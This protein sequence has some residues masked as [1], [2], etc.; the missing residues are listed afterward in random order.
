LNLYQYD[1]GCDGWAGEWAITYSENDLDTVAYGGAPEGCDSMT[2]LELELNREY[3]FSA[4]LT[5]DENADSEYSYLLVRTNED[6]AVDTISSGYAGQGNGFYVNDYSQDYGTYLADILTPDECELYANENG[7]VW[8]GIFCDAEYHGIEGG[9]YQVGNNTME[10]QSNDESLCE[11]EDEPNILFI[12]NMNFMEFFIVAFFNDWESADSLEIVN[13]V[14]IALE[15]GDDGFKIVDGIVGS[16]TGFVEVYADST[17]DSYGTVD[18]TNLQFTVENTVFYDSLGNSMLEVSGTIGPDIFEFLAGQTTTIDIFD[19][20]EMMGDNS[21]NETIYVSLFSDSTGYDITSVG[22]GDSAYIDTT[23]LDWYATSDSLFLQFQNDSSDGEDSLGTTNLNLAYTISNDTL[24]MFQF[25][26]EFTCDSFPDI[27]ACL[28]SLSEDDDLYFLRDLETI[29]SISRNGRA[30]WTSGHLVAIDNLDGLAPKKFELHSNYPNPFNPV[31][32][33]RFDI[34]K[35]IN[36]NTKVNV[37]DV[38]GRSIATLLNEPVGIGSYELQWNAK[39][40][41]SG[42]YFLEVV[43]GQNRQ[44]QKMILLK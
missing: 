2:E 32:T 30:I 31:T 14:A 22:D 44:S 13:P 40:F 5:G 7:Y 36:G 26:E 23:Y 38:N 11:Y 41:S 29:N 12:T 19:V 24:T 43:H 37:Y 1:S 4:G 20:E 10:W 16:D 34:D 15:L 25:E 17:M 8:D 33:I 9:C 27:D 35:Q 42:V 3:I 21:E 28:D 6:G 18:S 39:N